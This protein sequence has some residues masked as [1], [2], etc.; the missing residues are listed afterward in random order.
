MIREGTLWRGV[1]VALGA[2]VAVCAVA[3][4]LHE[5]TVPRE[6]TLLLVGSLVALGVGSTIANPRT[7]A[8]RLSPPEERKFRRRQYAV[9]FALSVVLA[10]TLLAKE[11]R[12]SM[13]AWLFVPIM[14]LP[15]I[16]VLRDVRG[17]YGASVVMTQPSIKTPHWSFWI[18][19]SAALLFNAAGCVNFGMQMVGAFPASMPEMHRELLATRPVWATA[20][21]AAAVFGGAIGCI[22]LLLRRGAAR[23][24]FALSLLGAVVTMVHTLGLAG[25]PAGPVQFVIGN[26]VQL[27]V[28]LFMLWYAAVSARRAWVR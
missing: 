25:Y 17:G 7:S 16:L 19:C 4:S 2:G 14:M 21:F 15:F 11:V 6:V 13:L 12:E 22:L 23:Y 24:L 8:T 27:L 3:N 26:L 28:T 10:L 20:A 5:N 18:I 1:G 9:G